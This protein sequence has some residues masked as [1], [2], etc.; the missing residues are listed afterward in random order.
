MR[1]PHCGLINPS[2]AQRCDC[3]YDFDKKAITDKGTP[4]VEAEPIS[5]ADRRW[6]WAAR[7]FAFICTITLGVGFVAEAEFNGPLLT[8]FTF[9]PWG[10]LSLVLL[11]FLFL[12][13]K[14]PLAFA[15]GLGTAAPFIALF[16]GAS[17]EFAWAPGRS[18]PN[19]PPVFF[20][21]L[22]FLRLMARLSRPPFVILHERFPELAT[23]GALLLWPFSISLAM[24]GLSTVVAFTKMAQEAKGMKK[25][26]WAFGAGVCFP[27]VLWLIIILPVLVVASFALHSF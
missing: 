7:C 4:P 11:G 15:L 19:W 26:R 17:G 22:F 18:M 25:L 10:L 1:C 24:L 16:G 8:L 2:T 3:G 23:I 27:L 5:M 20:F 21:P 12:R 9:G 14:N 6:L 13:G